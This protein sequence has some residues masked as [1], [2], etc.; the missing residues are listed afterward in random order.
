MS[1]INQIPDS[2]FYD[3]QSWIDLAPDYN[4]DD[5]AGAQGLTVEQLG[6]GVLRLSG[7]GAKSRGGVVEIDSDSAQSTG[8]GTVALDPKG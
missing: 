8:N 2:V 1:T 6:G 5:L 7:P 4:W 3:P